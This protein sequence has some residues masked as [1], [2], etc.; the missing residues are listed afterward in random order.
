MGRFRACHVLVQPRGRLR[1]EERKRRREIAIVGLPRQQHLVREHELGAEEEGRRARP[2][3]WSSGSDTERSRLKTHRRGLPGFAGCPGAG[4]PSRAL[5]SRAAPTTRARAA[6]RRRVGGARRCRPP[7]RGIVPRTAAGA[8]ASRRN[9]VTSTSLWPRGTP[10]KASIASAGNPPRPVEAVEQR[11]RVGRCGRRPSAVEPLERPFLGVEVA[12]V[13]IHHG[14][15]ID[16]P[17][18]LAASS[19]AIAALPFSR[20]RIGF[21][22]TSS[23]PTRP[24]SARSSHARCASR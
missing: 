11:R 17:S 7:R 3:A 20:S 1:V 21:T 23:E 5:G 8:G 9:T 22:S 16:C 12:R 4:E 10:A 15:R 24:D 14:Y 13:R 19:T 18:A 6:A 2:V